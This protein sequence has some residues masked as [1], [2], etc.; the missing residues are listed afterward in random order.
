MG[1]PKFHHLVPQ[2]YMKEWCYTKGKIYIFDKNKEYE[3]ESKDIEK[4]GGIRQFHT[5]KAGM[6]CGT[7]DDLQIIFKVLK[8]YKIIYKDKELDSLEGY[9]S[10]YYDFDNW[11][12]LNKDNNK[13]STKQKNIIKH[14]IDQSNVLDI[15]NLWDKKYESR[16]N[17]LLE[18]IKQKINENSNIQTDEFYKGL[19]I[20][21]I[22]SLDWRAFET[23]EQ[24]KNDFDEIVKLTE[25]NKIEIPENERTFKECKYASED[26]KHNLLL[27]FFSEFL[28]D[29]GVMYKIAQSY[30]KNLNIIFLKAPEDI[31]FI[32]SDNPSFTYIEDGIKNHIM[33]VTPKILIALVVNDTTINKYFIKDITV[34]EVKKYNKIIADNAYRHIIACSNNI[35]KSL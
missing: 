34:N 19:L 35:E 20:K 2:V 22:V 13:I 9:N 12:I 17:G 27:K 25:L 15:E 30:I 14:T 18:I 28:N 11:I 21:W 1:N 26:I 8:D 3:F 29:K 16:W 5:I 32:T 10:K 7:E 24:F 6:C 31:E 4:F 23:N 33:P